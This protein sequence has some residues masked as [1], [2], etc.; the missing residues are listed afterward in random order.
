MSVHFWEDGTMQ[1]RW[2][3]TW[4]SISLRKCP[5]EIGKYYGNFSV[6]L[7]SQWE[8]TKFISPIPMPNGAYREIYRMYFNDRDAG[9]VTLKLQICIYDV[10]N[11][12]NVM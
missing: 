10:E 5:F 8:S 6:E 4:K 3:C 2:L 11:A 1:F 9:G 12:D 7:V